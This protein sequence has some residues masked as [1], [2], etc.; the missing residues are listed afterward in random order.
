MNPFTMRSKQLHLFTAALACFIFI[1][2]EKT[3][4]QIEPGPPLSDYLPLE[5]GKYI[6]YRLDST[7]FTN[8]GTQ[9]ATH[10][11]EEKQIVDAKIP[12]ASGR[13]SYRILRFLRDTSGASSWSPAGT[14]FITPTGKTVEVIDNNL[15]VIK[16]ISPIKQDNTWKG[17]RYLPD[18]AYSSLYNFG[19]DFLM[20][21]WDYTYSA[22]DGSLTLK[23]KTYND[24][25]T[26]DGIDEEFNANAE[27]FNVISSSSIGYVNRIKDV[28]ARN[29]GLIYQEFIMWEYQPPN[30][31]NPVGGKVGFGIK[32]SIID[33]N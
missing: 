17:N 12:D 6:T 25:L 31:S 19:N 33:H 21:D 27:T 3:T 1:S 32:R 22:I 16:L 5:V 24:V 4:E 18:E 20:D 10:Y 9:N 29:L 11:Y 8:F 15:R 2:C 23:G 7:I 28:Y 26:V 13:D 30:A 14:Y